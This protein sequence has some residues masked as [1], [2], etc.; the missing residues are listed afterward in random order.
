MVFLYA[1]G[2]NGTS[3]T[4]GT[5]E[6]FSNRYITPA[7]DALAEIQQTGDIFF[8][9]YWLKGLLAG[10]KSVEASSMVSQWIDT[11]PEVSLMNKLKENA[12]PLSPKP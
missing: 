11:H 4:N 9:G 3:G 5:R 1:L 10:H 12:Y 7:L 6:P 2:T 8:P